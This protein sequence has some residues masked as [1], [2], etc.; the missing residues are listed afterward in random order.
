MTT[1]KAEAAVGYAKRGIK[2]FP[3]HEVVVTDTDTGELGCSCSKGRECT[4]AG[5]HPRTEDGFESATN[6]PE[7][8][9]ARWTRWPN[10]NI[11]MPT[12][13][14]NNVAV[15]DGDGDIGLTTLEKRG[16]SP[17][18]PRVRTGSGGLHVYTAYPDD[19]DIPSKVKEYAPGIDTRGKGGYV[20]LPPSNHISGSGYS[21]ERELNGHVPDAPA[22]LREEIL[23]GA[24]KSKAGKSEGAAHR[25]TIP[26]GKRDDALTSAGG[27]MRRY[28]F[29]EDA[30]RAGLM[31]L[32]QERCNPP[33]ADAQ[34]AKIAKSVAR[35]EPSA[36]IAGDGAGSG[37]LPPALPFPIESMPASTQDLIRQAAA[38]IGC[39]PEFIAVPMMATLAGAIGNTRAFEIKKG[40]K[41]TCQIFAAVVGKP[42]SGKSPAQK[43][44]V[45]PANKLQLEYREI[46]RLK[47]QAYEEEKREYD[48]LPKDD[49]EKETPPPEPRPDDVYTD[50][51]TVEATGALLARN[52]RGLLQKNDELAAHFKGMNQY[53]GGQGSDPYFYNSAFSGQTVKVDRKGDLDNPLIVPH[54]FLSIVGGIQPDVLSEVG[55]DK[56]EGSRDRY[57]I[58][59]PEDMP[60]APFSFEN[61]IDPVAQ[62]KYEALYYSVYALKPQL[63]DGRPGP[64]VLELSQEA[65]EAFAEAMDRISG[66]IAGGMPA[67]LGGVWAKLRTYLPR[68]CLLLAVC[69]FEEEQG[70][71]E[72]RVTVNE[73]TV[74]QLPPGEN[75][76]D[77]P[78]EG[79]PVTDDSNDSH[80]RNTVTQEVT[81]EKWPL[82]R[83]LDVTK[84]TKLIEYFKGMAL[85]AHAEIYKTPV[86]KP[87]DSLAAGIIA[88]L[89]NHDGRFEGSSEELRV[90]LKAAGVSNIPDDPSPFSR[91]LRAIVGSTDS[92]TMV[93]KTRKKD[94]RP[95]VLTHSSPQLS[96][97]SSVTP[98]P[99]KPIDKR[100][101]TG[102]SQVTVNSTFVTREPLSPTVTPEPEPIPEPPPPDE[103]EDSPE[104]PHPG[105][106]DDGLGEHFD[107]GQ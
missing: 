29:S 45:A 97:L 13:K 32:N 63:F 82:I 22:W 60:P 84:A 8:V 27:S 12:G 25:E 41:E 104:P 52:P 35:Y 30:I 74:T 96:P 48:N 38:A 85:R 23:K 11:G 100:K 73:I 54:P 56:D 40:W 103:I 49:R 70:N 57:L 9:A 89:K 46:Y 4:D 15:I 61:T 91:R 86:D 34:V 68:L 53:K 69:R 19:M 83:L 92:L 93:N 33:L 71:L 3:V 62:K 6:D 55:S 79:E 20:L 78:N 76:I 72:E 31:V 47:R 106:L 43:I 37:E 87:E 75:C 99:E 24:E 39:P 88:Y 28:G 21:W 58:A 59:Y 2:V 67:R 17:Q 64:F 80:P 36:S 51:A 101:S 14:V 66:E 50:N 98:D 102:D 26:Q 90:E 81:D 95:F 18:A 42:G 16:Y 105:Y 107:R 1:A 77:K 65:K 94:Y 44:G 7:V 5:K 10:A